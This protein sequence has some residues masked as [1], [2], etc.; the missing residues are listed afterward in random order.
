M[1][2]VPC[3]YSKTNQIHACQ[4]QKFP[5][6]LDGLVGFDGLFVHYMGQMAQKIIFEAQKS[7]H[8]SAGVV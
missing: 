3:P 8:M 7:D 4:E 1:A 5:G 2:H 6:G